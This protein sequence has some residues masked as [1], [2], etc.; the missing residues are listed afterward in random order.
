MFMHIF[1]TQWHRIKVMIY[2]QPMTGWWPFCCHL[3]VGKA[4][5]WLLITVGVSKLSHT[6]CNQL[7][8]C[9]TSLITSSM[10]SALEGDVGVCRGWSWPRS[11]GQPLISSLDTDI[12]INICWSQA[13]AYIHKWREAA[14]GLLLKTDIVFNVSFLSIVIENQPVNGNFWMLWCKNGQIFTSY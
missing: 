9:S 5:P 7:A 1:I 13:Y 8:A 4:V 12:S 10:R 14:L 2:G 3:T 6:A 11:H